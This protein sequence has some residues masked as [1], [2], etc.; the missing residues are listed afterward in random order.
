MEELGLIMVQK[1]KERVES[2]IPYLPLEIQQLYQNTKEGNGQRWLIFV[3]IPAV[4]CYS[5]NRKPPA[6]P[7]RIRS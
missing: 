1:E 7:V 3:D 6:M 5:N 2:L 4:A